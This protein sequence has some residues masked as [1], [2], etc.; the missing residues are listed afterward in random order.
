VNINRYFIITVFLFAHSL[1]LWAQ[2]RPQDA[3]RV[4]DNRL[5]F[6]IDLQ[7]TMAQRREVAS[8]FDL[9]SAVLAGVWAGKSEIRLNGVS[10]RVKKISSRIVELSKDLNGT[11]PDVADQSDVIMIDDQMAGI[12]METT[13]ESL[14]YGI[15]K[16]T[17]FSSFQYVHGV[18]K[19][20]LPGRTDAKNVVL[21]G[22]F[23]NWSTMQ[24]PMHRT[25]SGW[26][27]QLK[28]KPGKY[29]YKYVVDGRWMND[30]FNRQKEDDGRGGENSVV[31][32]YNHWFRLSG[33]PTAKRVVLAG[34]F[35]GWNQDELKMI[36][37]G[38]TWLLNL[39]LRDG[40]HAY[41][42]LVNGHWI[43]DPQARINRPDGAGHINSFIGVGD[44][45]MFILKGYPNARQV[46]LSGNF[47][48]WNTGELF[49]EKTPGGWRLP[50]A[51]AP[52]MYEYK[53]IV[54]GDWITDPSN[55]VQSGAGNNAN[56][57]LVFKPNHTF[58]LE[59]Y[60]DAKKVTIAGSFNGWNKDSYLMSRTGNKWSFPVRLHPGKYTYKF[61][62]DNKWIL[63]PAN[64]LWEENEYGTDN[65]VIW[66][67]P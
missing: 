19:F 45:N 28:L 22:T 51:L 47:N 61:V 40:T 60:A 54:D 64:P 20:F 25:D 30:P 9:D 8:L 42:Y 37:S 13:R 62:V 67:E 39:Y 7:W 27:F 3:C 56:S 2:V 4:D 34:S 66:I 53:F 52:G 57:V 55:P 43:N 24:M 10:W 14:P 26:V 29:C 11:V 58:I 44:S 38:N 33:Y 12:T 36:K 48:A 59:G 46:V 32:C 15:N 49:M 65:S 17:R 1:N 18:A 23:N 63:D 50:Y 5:L 21:S 6:T 41:K 16:F 35:N 31:F